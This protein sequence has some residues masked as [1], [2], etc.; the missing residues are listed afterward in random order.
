[1]DSGGY[2]ERSF[3]PNEKNV[4][5]NHGLYMIFYLLEHVRTV[6][7]ALCA[8]AAAL[9]TSLL[10][11]GIITF[12]A[13]FILVP[14]L[15]LITFSVVLVWQS[16]QLDPAAPANMEEYFI[17]NDAK[18]AKSYKNTK[19]PVETFVEAYMNQQIDF[20]ANVDPLKVF[21]A[22]WNVFRMCITFGHFKFFLAKFV[23]Q[24]VH[25]SQSADT[26][27]VR[28]V[29]DRG[30]DF[31]NWFLGERMIYTSGIF[32]SQNDTLTEAQD[33]KL[34][35]VCRQTKMK[36]G[37]KHLDIGCGWGTLL[38]HAAKYFG[39]H[40][41]G[42]TLAREQRK[43]GLDQAK[44]YGVVD[45][46]N[47][48]C[49]DYRDIPNERYDVVTCLEMAEHVGIKNFQ[50]FLLQ[51]KEMLKDDGFFYLQIAGLRRAWQYEDL[52]WGL[53]M[54]TYIFPAA[55]ASCP[56]GFV[57]TQCERAGYEVHRV[58]NCGVH[59]GLTINCW[60]NQWLSNKKAVVEKYGEWWFRLW[61]VFLAWSTIVASQGSSTVFMI[62]LHKNTTRF[63]R[64]NNFV[65]EHVIAHQM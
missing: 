49:M 51:V 54:G 16:H 24:L 12:I 8:V 32:E 10:E 2:K 13:S 48:L 44:D 18:L 21:W 30:N 55:D 7:P 27:D 3:P 46:V 4:G 22:R 62:T 37:A 26:V 1:M 15:C 39:T 57:T 33:R 35:L 63:D 28:E 52:I 14:V 38:C 9:L 58:E 56:L 64:R 61:V 36:P 17:F 6:V 42:V 23:G 41:T 47:I 60:Y 59:Y 45:R 65:G 20:K 29:Y 19:I 25:H 50:T 11:G 53:F 5:G 43:W 40:S 34:D 31:Y